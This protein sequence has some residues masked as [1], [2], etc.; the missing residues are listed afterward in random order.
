[1]VAAI[2]TTMKLLKENIH[3]NRKNKSDNGCN[4]SKSIPKDTRLILL[5]LFSIIDAFFCSGILII[6]ANDI[7]KFTLQECS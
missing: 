1:M 6:I 2:I 3:E 4:A 5:F 7:N